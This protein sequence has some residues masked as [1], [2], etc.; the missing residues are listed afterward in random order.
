MKEERNQQP[1]A[2]STSETKDTTSQSPKNDGE[3]LK[4]VL[5]VEVL[6]I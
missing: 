4:K 6:D 1:T 2:T 3:E 5:E